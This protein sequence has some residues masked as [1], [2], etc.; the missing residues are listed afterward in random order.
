MNSR[1]RGVARSTTATSRDGDS[2]CAP[3]RKRAAWAYSSVC[4]PLFFYTRFWDR[5]FVRGYLVSSTT[6]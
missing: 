1:G 3:Q 4:P 5:P 6:F 2:L